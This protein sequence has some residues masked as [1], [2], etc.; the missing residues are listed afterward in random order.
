MHQFLCK[1][2]TSSI[3][4]YKI[5]LPSSSW[6]ILAASLLNPAI[7]T[8]R[9]KKDTVV[10]V[11]A[12][13]NTSRSLIY[14]LNTK[15]IIGLKIY[16]SKFDLNFMKTDSNYVSILKRTLDFGRPFKLHGLIN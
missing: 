6:L 11:K 7:T 1:W 12:K 14:S 3:Q 10:K 13:K 2:Y 4:R 5:N 16:S 8:F 9:T 15:Q